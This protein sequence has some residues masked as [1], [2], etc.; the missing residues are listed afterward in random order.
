MDDVELVA[1][2]RNVIG[3]GPV[4]DV[5]RARLW[6]IDILGSSLH[7]YSPVTRGT[8]AVSLGRHVGAVALRQDGGMVAAVKD[9]SRGN[10]CSSVLA[11]S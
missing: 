5:G 9:G 11:Q 4:W 1:D 6:W 2:S 3:E 8:G 10:P 7:W